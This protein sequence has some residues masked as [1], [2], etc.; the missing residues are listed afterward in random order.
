[1]T[2]VPNWDLEALVAIARHYPKLELLSVYVDA[3]IPV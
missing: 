1:M 3:T 2:A